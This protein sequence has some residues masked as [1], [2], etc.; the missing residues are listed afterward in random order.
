MDDPARRYRYGQKAR[1]MA[2]A[3]YDLSVVAPRYMALFRQAMA[4]R[5]ART[6]RPARR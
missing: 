2:R 1:S 6:G 3:Q 4:N 5:A